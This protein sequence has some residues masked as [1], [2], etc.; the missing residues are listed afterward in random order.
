MISTLQA[1]GLSFAGVI[2]LYQLSKVGIKKYRVHKL[3]SEQQI[4]LNELVAITD[5]CNALFDIDSEDYREPIF[6][7]LIKNRK[8]DME[9]FL[10]ASLKCDDLNIKHIPSLVKNYEYVHRQITNS[11]DYLELK[12]K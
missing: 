1:L 4:A 5:K 8:P 12:N 3:T 6:S 9:L 7:M 2:S 11:L 10:K